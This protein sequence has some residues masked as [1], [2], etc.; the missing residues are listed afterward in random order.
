MEQ[1]KQ[2]EAVLKK[3]VAMYTMLTGKA[4]TEREGRAFIEIFDMTEAY[5]ASDIK[6]TSAAEAFDILSHVD[7]PQFVGREVG[8]DGEATLHQPLKELL[9]TPPALA[10]LA[11]HLRETV[12]SGKSWL[13][14][15]PAGI[16][17]IPRAKIYADPASPAGDRT[18]TVDLE[19]V[20][21]R[22]DINPKVLA[23][24]AKQESSENKTPI[25]GIVET[26]SGVV[27]DGKRYSPP[28]IK[29][30]SRD[31]ILG[32]DWQIC[33]LSRAKNMEDSYAV[34]FAEMPT[35]VQF[36]EHFVK[37]HERTHYVHVNEW[38][39]HGWEGITDRY[40]RSAPAAALTKPNAIVR[41]A[42]A[43]ELRG[44]DVSLPPMSADWEQPEMP[45][46]I[47]YYSDAAKGAVFFYT[48]KKPTAREM[49]HFHH[50]KCLAIV[51]A[52]PKD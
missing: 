15:S 1:E 21:E 41:T 50:T 39:N 5:V 34:H 11:E 36:N 27:K 10:G 48:D 32:Y 22:L 31:H 40:D 33:V 45:W 49:A 4:M 47:R 19:K 25:G 9:K 35:Q 6:T 37:F 43:P 13:D 2:F 46:R 29:C 18:A 51:Q 17:Q 14:V 20:A 52:K 7:V 3:S 8:R 42:P 38:V 24:V 26:D 44:R 28:P 16:S 12:A 23:T 30:S